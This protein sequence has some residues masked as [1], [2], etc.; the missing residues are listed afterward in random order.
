MMTHLGLS[1]FVVAVQ[2]GAVAS[3]PSATILVLETNPALQDLIDQALRESG[4]RVLTTNNALEALELLHRV[5]VDVV[6]LG[7]LLE[8]R[9]A[10]LLEELRSIQAGLRIVSISGP[11]DD[12]EGME[13]AAR[14]CCPFSLNDLREAAG[15]ALDSRAGS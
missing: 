6:V 5:R 4:H 11:D 2:R 10:T 1:P 7:E 15:A 14:L 13:A 3:G 8:E 9:G 12:L